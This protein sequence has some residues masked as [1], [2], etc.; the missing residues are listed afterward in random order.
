MRQHRLKRHAREPAK[1]RISEQGLL[2]EAWAACILWA[3]QNDKLVAQFNAATGNN[4]GKTLTPIERMIDKATGHKEN[5]AEVDEFVR[6]VTI[7]YWGLRHA[8]KAIR[9]RIEAEQ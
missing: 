6:W 8:P 5:L 3:A 2:D 9:E 1:K 7:N 4:F